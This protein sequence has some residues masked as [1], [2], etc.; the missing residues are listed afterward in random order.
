MVSEQRFRQVCGDVCQWLRGFAP[1]DTGNLAYNAI[2]IEYPSPN[3]CLIYVDESIAP[4]MKY[5]EFPWVSPRWNGKKNPNEGWWEQAGVNVY[6]RLRRALR[7]R[8]TDWK[9][10]DKMWDEYKEW[11]RDWRHGGNDWAKGISR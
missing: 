9:R 5:T 8:S 7:G 6:V 2:K 11:F 1:K 4:Y 3:V 10:D